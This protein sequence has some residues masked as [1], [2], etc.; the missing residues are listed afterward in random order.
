MQ[1]IKTQDDIKKLGTI[2]GIWAHPDDE[3]FTMGGI[4]AAA[5]RNGQDVVCITATRGEKGVQNESRWPAA[6]LGQIRTDELKA[7]MKIIGVKKLYW[8]DYPD[9]EC[10]KIAVEDALQQIIKCIKECQP[11]SILTFGADGLTGHPDHKAVSSWAKKAAREAGSK[12]VI[13][14]AIQTNQQYKAMLKVDKQFG[15]FFNIDKPPVCEPE[16]C[17]I[18]FELDDVGYAQK[19]A[20]L[21][22]MPSQYETL[23]KAFEDSL[24]LSLGTEAFLCV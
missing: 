1:T 12:A 9:G 16:Q 6:R 21:K 15:I 24:Q 5:I 8:L 10:K 20:A 23:L 18:C 13:Y 4:M 14:H 3:T 17:A 11:D 19:H 2:M 7:A 22:A